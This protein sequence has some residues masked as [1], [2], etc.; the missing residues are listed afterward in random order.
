MKVSSP[1]NPRARGF[2]LIELLVVIAIIAILIGLLLPAVQKVREAAARSK[3]QNNLKQ[4]GIGLHA[5]HDALQ[6]FPGAGWNQVPYNVGAGSTV[7]GSPPPYNAAN[8]GSWLFQILP[9]VEQQSVYQSTLINTIT[10]TPIPIYF[11]PSR[12]A[13]ATL[14]GSATTAGNDYYGNGLV[15][16]AAGTSTCTSVVPVGVFRPYCAGAITLTGITDGTS[17]TIM[18]GEKNLCLA[19]LNSGNDITDKNGSGYSRGWDYGGSGNWDGTVASGPNP[20]NVADLPN[21][22]GCTSGTHYYGSSHTGLTN[23]LFGDGAVRQVRFN[24]SS[25]SNNTNT[26]WLL[27]HVSDGNP[28]PA[29]Y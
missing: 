17:N 10:G 18:A 26:T 13:P 1:P 14:S 4:I 11:C 2:T 7:S 6:R 3:C 27:L 12:R 22:T 15:T 21:S 24:T 28:T 20:S 19:S 29:N 25:V 5:C 9:Y 23:M 16:S 8:S